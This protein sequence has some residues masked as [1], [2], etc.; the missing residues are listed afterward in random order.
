MC[1]C[2][3]TVTRPSVCGAGVVPVEFRPPGVGERRVD[4]RRLQTVIVVRRALRAAPG[5]AVPATSRRGVVG[6]GQRTV[7]PAAVVRSVQHHDAPVTVRDAVRLQ[8]HLVGVCNV[9]TFPLSHRFSQSSY[10]EMQRAHRTHCV[11]V[12]VDSLTGRSPGTVTH[13]P[14]RHGEPG[15][16]RW[17]VSGTGLVSGGGV[18]T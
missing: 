10:C 1:C 15:L 5:R 4:G 3:C 7:L 12:P 8:Y 14:G 17:F 6:G 2:R 9:N 18:Q 16:S 11:P 13:R